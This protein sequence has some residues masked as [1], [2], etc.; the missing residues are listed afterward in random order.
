MFEDLGVHISYFDISLRRHLG[1]IKETD[2]FNETIE[3]WIEELFRLLK[4][5]SMQL[6]ASL[7]RQKQRKIVQS[8]RGFILPRIL[9]TG[10]QVDAIGRDRS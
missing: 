9:V 3:G 6:Q 8:V 10:Y 7:R 4:K 2:M 5:V 1:D